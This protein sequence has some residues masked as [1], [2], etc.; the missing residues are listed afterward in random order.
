MFPILSS[1]YILVSLIR[2]ACLTNCKCFD[3]T[4]IEIQSEVYKIT[5]FPV[6]HHSLLRFLSQIFLALL[7]ILAFHVFSV[8]IDFD[9]CCPHCSFFEFSKVSVDFPKVLWIF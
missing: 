6:M 3:L 8:K 4:T 9:F 2:A 1:E 7:Y 5:S